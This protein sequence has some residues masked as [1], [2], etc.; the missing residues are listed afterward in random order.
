MTK[1]ARTFGAAGSLLALLAVAGAAV[2]S[3]VLASRLDPADIARVNLALAFQG[4]HA[5]ALVLVALLARERASRVLA[6]AG[7]AFVLGIALFCG[8]LYAKA[9]YG[10]SSALAPFGGV[11]LMLGWGALAVYFLVGRRD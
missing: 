11:L 10:A 7:T 8:S 5:L 2:A 6:V 4:G 1:T 3:H 9:L